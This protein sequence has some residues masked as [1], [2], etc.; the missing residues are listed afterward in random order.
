ME[1]QKGVGSVSLRNLADYSSG[2]AVAELFFID[3]ARGCPAAGD[4][5]W[6]A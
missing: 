4:F 2:V 5:T 1:T 3:N 6:N